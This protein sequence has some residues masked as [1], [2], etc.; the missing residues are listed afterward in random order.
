MQLLGNV[1]MAMV[2]RLLLSVRLVF[3]LVVGMGSASLC[4]SPRFLVSVQILLLPK[5]AIIFS[6][7]FTRFTA[8]QLLK[9]HCLA[10]LGFEIMFG[11]VLVRAN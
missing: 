1:D 8:I 3:V 4:A 6:T 2:L 10:H 5:L 9:V 7:S 11:T